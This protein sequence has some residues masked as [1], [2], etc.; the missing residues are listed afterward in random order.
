MRYDQIKKSHCHGA[1]QVPKILGRQ[2]F[3]P[4]PSAQVPKLSRAKTFLDPVPV[5]RAQK[6][7]RCRLLKL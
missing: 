5:H 4:C 6:F 1:A 3:G 7:K 2:I